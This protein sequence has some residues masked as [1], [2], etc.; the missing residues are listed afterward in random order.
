MLWRER[1]Q[2]H[3]GVG[4]RKWGSLS[5]ARSDDERIM[6]RPNAQ[7]HDLAEDAM[8]IED[9]RTS[10]HLTDVMHKLLSNLLNVKRL[11]STPITDLIGKNNAINSNGHFRPLIRWVPPTCER[12]CHQGDSTNKRVWKGKEAMVEEVGKIGVRNMREMWGLNSR[13]LRFYLGLIKGNLTMGWYPRPE[14]QDT[15]KD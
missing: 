11:G 8:M 1:S 13:E 2:A 9:E 5:Y 6:K 15:I 12:F 7:V 4:L 10:K 3:F 14:L